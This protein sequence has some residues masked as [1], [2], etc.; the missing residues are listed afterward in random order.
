MSWKLLWQLPWISVAIALYRRI[1]ADGRGNCCGLTSAE[2][3]VAI[4]ADFRGLRWL[5]PRSLPRTEPAMSR[6]PCRG[7]P[8]ISTVA[9]GNT[10]GSPRKCRGHC[11]GPPSKSKKMCIR[12]RVCSVGK[13]V[14]SGEKDML[15]LVRRDRSGKWSEHGRRARAIYNLET[16]ETK[17]PKT[18]F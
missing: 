3:T 1:T 13:L 7:H 5:V 11:R 2:I 15:T 14:T 8:R 17:E 10:H 6:G 18:G 9:R 4:A 12:A 16:L